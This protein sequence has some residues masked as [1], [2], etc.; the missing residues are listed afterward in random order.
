MF[1]TDSIDYEILNDSCEYIS[2]NNVPGNIIELGTRKGGSA[3]LIADSLERVEDTNRLFIC[4]DP[5]GNI[6]YAS[7]DQHLSIKFDYNNRMRN[8]TIPSLFSYIT[9]LGFNFQ[10]FNLEDTEFFSRYADGIPVYNEVKKIE[11]KYALVFI[12]GPHCTDS[13]LLEAEFFIPRISING[14]IIFDDIPYYDHQQVEDKM[15]ISGFEI[16][17]IS[18]HK[19]AYKRVN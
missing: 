19:K 18:K 5:Y 12:D 1:E 13:V 10:F 2:K 4:V 14:I 16:F 17:A 11:S 15:L 7:S 8:E 3:V 9:D 6:N